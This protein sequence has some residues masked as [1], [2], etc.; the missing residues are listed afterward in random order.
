L[1]RSFHSLSVG[2][3]RR[4]RPGCLAVVVGRAGDGHAAA[5]LSPLIPV[6][7]DHPDVQPETFSITDHYRDDPWMLVRL[8]TIDQDDLRDLLEESWRL[9]APKRFLSAPEPT[10]KAPQR[11]SSRKPRG[12]Q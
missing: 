4:Q 7:P 1:N 6:R 11:D 8:A 10:D 9:S 2:P 5:D 12:G 3:R